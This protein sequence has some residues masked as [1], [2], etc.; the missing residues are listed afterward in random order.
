[1]S[2]LAMSS[3][4]MSLRLRGRPQETA[5][6]TNGTPIASKVALLVVAAIAVAWVTWA[7]SRGVGVST[8]S[9][10]YG[11]AARTL[12]TD[13]HLGSPL[14]GPLV[15]FPP[16]LSILLAAGRALGLSV[17]SADR[18]LDIASILLLVPAA[19][20]LGLDTTGSVFA[21]VGVAA[22]SVASTVTTSVFTMMWSEPPF[23]VIVT[24]VLAVLVRAV[25]RRQLGARSVVA[26]VAGASAAV[27]IRYTGVAILPVIAFG[28]YLATRRIG[29]AVAVTAGSSAGFVAVV[30]RNVAVGGP[31]FGY[32]E[33]GAAAVNFF[34]A[35]IGTLGYLLVPSMRNVVGYG[36]FVL[37]V[38][39]VLIAARGR[40]FRV[41]LVA[42]F[43]VAWWALLLYGH[44]RGIVDPNTRLLAPAVP[45]T[46]VVVAY[47]IARLRPV[48][49]TAAILL[50][51]TVIVASSERNF[52]QASIKA[53][54]GIGFAAAYYP[55]SA[56]V[57]AVRALP[58]SAL[59]ASDQAAV[60][61]WLTGHAPIEEIP[62]NFLASANQR[63]SMLD[64]L[65]SSFR[66]RAGYVA[67]L[68]PSDRYATLEQLGSIGINCRQTATPLYS[69]S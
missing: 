64:R 57:A 24:A 9:S 30:A 16:G 11:W 44:L 13:G 45:A 65:T 68:V 34:T 36:L 62:S 1:M 48:W 8:D 33:G 10:Q 20:R 26:L 14:G 50:A 28:V 54:D 12:A 41:L 19:Y 7:T 60:L 15:A 53:T 63:A 18:A 38:A 6:P 21:G 66:H 59:I 25:D 47:G 61:A 5:R 51:A 32:H 49:R 55:D 37:L 43:L 22:A 17:S 56:T 27:S 67:V 69:C 3:L 4:A 2:S 58:H 40:Q 29:R 42:G 52:N 39:G 46:A 35:G 23:I 31:A